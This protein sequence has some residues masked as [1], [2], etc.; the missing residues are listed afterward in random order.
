T[1][2]V[3]D[4]NSLLPVY[5]RDAVRVAATGEDLAVALRTGRNATVV[6]RFDHAR[7]GGFARAWRTLA[8]PGFSVFLT[9]I[10]SG[11]FDTFDALANH[12]ELRMDADAAGNVAVG[13]V[14]RFQAAPL[15]DAHSR[16]FGGTISA[17]NGFIVTRIA[18]DGTR[19]GATIVDTGR[20]SELH[21]LRVS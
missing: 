18:P 16:F 6:Y 12:W 14:A 19:R 9:G 7:P 8:E 2:S 10:E 4:D 11:S 13:V 1:G 20:Q 21:G 3:H 17:I 15:F 5:T